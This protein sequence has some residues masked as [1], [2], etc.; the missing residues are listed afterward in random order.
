MKNAAEKK[1]DAAYEIVDRL[2]L[3]EAEMDLLKR[4]LAAALVGLQHP[5]SGPAVARA[6]MEENK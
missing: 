1:L 3:P 5:C 6:M 2:A 4:A